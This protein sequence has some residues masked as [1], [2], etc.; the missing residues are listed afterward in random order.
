MYASVVLT[1]DHSPFKTTYQ[2]M[3]TIQLQLEVEKRS[4]TG[5][6]PFDMGLELMNR[7]SQQ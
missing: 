2:T 7:W 3:S 4:L 1:V 6:L 5:D